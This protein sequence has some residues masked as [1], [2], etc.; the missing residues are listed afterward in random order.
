MN[1]LRLNCSIS[2]L[3]LPSNIGILTVAV[4]A[5]GVNVALYRP[6]VKSDPAVQKQLYNYILLKALPRVC[7]ENTALGGMSRDK[8]SMRQS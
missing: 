4:V 3:L 6:G 1:N 8:D 2:S 7:M 5:P